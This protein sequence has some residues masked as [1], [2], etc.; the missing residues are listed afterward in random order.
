MWRRV[1]KFVASTI[2]RESTG[3]A[4]E[5]LETSAS[6][7]VLQNDAMR[8]LN[9]AIKELSK[10]STTVA[11]STIKFNDQFTNKALSHLKDSPS[12]SDMSV[13]E[14]EAVARV[15]YEGNDA[16]P[17]DLSKAVE[18]WREATKKGSIEGKYSLAMCLREGV[19]TEVDKLEAFKLMKE[20]A[21]EHNYHLGNVRIHQR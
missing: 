17:K 16:V 20:L 1:I 11:N 3:N 19:G 4:A 15:F 2:G 12:L 13:E 10:D 8:D 21:D 18:V 14:L 7:P 5:A 6:R 9:D